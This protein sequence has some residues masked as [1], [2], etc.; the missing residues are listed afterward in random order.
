[1]SWDPSKF[2]TGLRAPSL[3][4]QVLRAFT[5]RI[6]GNAQ[7]FQVTFSKVE[8][9][10]WQEIALGKKER[11][12]KGLTRSTIQKDLKNLGIKPLTEKRGRENQY[13]SDDVRAY[14]IFDKNKY[15]SQKAAHWDQC[16]KLD[17]Q[18]N[19]Q[20]HDFISSIIDTIP[21]SKELMKRRLASGQ[22]LEAPNGMRLLDEEDLEGIR[23]AFKKDLPRTKRNK[24]SYS[25]KAH[26]LYS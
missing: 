12:L 2:D 1:M 4:T 5:S 10:T 11:G 25:A 15:K 14:I 13:Y 20:F 24:K 22:P 9:Y 18:T 7:G 8:A 16:E 21:A 19:Q 17:I 3:E 26:N 6:N 23:Q